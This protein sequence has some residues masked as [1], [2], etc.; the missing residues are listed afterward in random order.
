MLVLALS[1][2]LTLGSLL[3]VEATPSPT[4]MST[5][6]V[7]GPQAQVPIALVQ[8][9]G[10][11][12]YAV[13]TKADELGWPT[14]W[15]DRYNASGARQ[16]SHY[17]EILRTPA[18]NGYH[19]VRAVA[20]N[21]QE[22]LYLSY[23]SLL[24]G[25]TTGLIKLG[26]DGALAWERKIEKCRGSASL[27][28]LPGG[29]DVIMTCG[30]GATR[31]AQLDGAELWRQSWTPAQ[32]TERDHKAAR[33]NFNNVYV[34]SQHE[35]ANTHGTTQELALS[36]FTAEGTLLWRTSVPYP[37]Y[38]Q[39]SMLGAFV[40]K[41]HGVLVALVRGGSDGKH[42]PIELLR[43]N[44]SGA[45][46]GTHT[47]ET[48]AYIHEPSK[49][50]VIVRFDAADE[51][52]YVAWDNRSYDM[53]PATEWRAVSVR[54][55][56]VEDPRLGEAARPVAR[57]APK[58]TGSKAQPSDSVAVAPPGAGILSKQ[59]QQW[60]G[61][62]QQQH[63]IADP[64]HDFLVDMDV[65]GVGRMSL[66]GVDIDELT[67][68]VRVTTLSRV[69]GGELKT[70][71]FRRE[72]RHARPVDMF[73]HNDRVYVLAEDDEISGPAVGS[74]ADVVH[75]VFRLGGRKRLTSAS[76]GPAKLPAPRPK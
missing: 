5:A 39:P 13:Y 41:D 43:F 19:N 40:T 42:E 73:V 65:D 74:S 64:G 30:T 14:L 11:D 76:K 27:L 33:D 7:G 69:S 26:V 35:G 63:T 48:G 28:P 70:T 50:P 46:Q 66:V 71:R 55:S 47:I 10:G 60:V 52:A 31:R 68:Y 2:T 49:H 67:D 29:G 75:L 21:S 23:Y 8:A 15:V 6:A 12:H 3:A 38:K 17:H 51:T 58:A 16:W 54:F 24:N 45:H 20:T 9:K 61:T 62:V 53:K 22:T 44:H 25:G 57:R 56:P 4:L 59:A 36:K 1:S 37:K 34:A 72:G 18:G 32:T